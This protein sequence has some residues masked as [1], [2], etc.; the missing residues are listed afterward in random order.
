MHR[1]PTTTEALRAVPMKGATLVLLDPLNGQTCSIADIYSLKS[2]QPAIP[3]VV[4]TSCSEHNSIMEALAAG[5]DGYL[6]HPL[7]ADQFLEIL[8]ALPS[9]NTLLCTRARNSL[10]AA[11]RSLSD[12]AQATSL[13]W[14]ERQVVTCLFSHLSTKEMSTRFGIS[15][16]TIHAHL[17]HI[18]IKLGVRSRGEVLRK[19]MGL[20]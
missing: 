12:S 13:T 7:S 15:E 20:P 3:T 1:F 8:A 19:C 5:A 9:G 2:A 11:F 16:G 10:V 6:I 4:Y 17:T 14:R 18:F